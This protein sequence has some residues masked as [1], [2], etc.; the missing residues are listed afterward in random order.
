M[1][2]DHTLARFEPFGERLSKPIYADYSFA[3]IPATAH[4]L[5]TGETTGPLLP[6]DCFGGSYP[7]P[8][9]VVLVFI[10]SFGW[11]FWK[12][13]WQQSRIMRRVVEDGVLTPIS[14]LTSPRCVGS[15]HHR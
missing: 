3:N 1:I 12:R 15:M 13:W 11:E 4:F 14:A 8:E 6:A 7:K 10:D 9:K 2:N 5:L